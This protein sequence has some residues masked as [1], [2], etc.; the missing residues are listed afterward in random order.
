MIIK[1]HP[2]EKLSSILT[3]NKNYIY[4]NDPIPIEL[5]DLKDV[6][7]IAGFGSM[8]LA[9]AAEKYP[10]KKS[11]SLIKLLPSKKLTEKIILEFDSICKK[12]KLFY[13]VSFEEL[14]YIIKK[15]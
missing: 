8:A 5:Y 9:R 14:K 11:L 13:P 2:K 7:L 6:N 15:D 4:I 1:K 10:N 12:N 3:D